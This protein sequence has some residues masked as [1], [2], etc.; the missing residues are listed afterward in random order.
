[1]IPKTAKV[2]VV[3]D[4]VVFRTL[5]QKALSEL[6]YVNLETA[7]NGEEALELLNKAKEAGQPFELVLS[8]W[9][10]PKMDGLDLLKNCRKNEG[11]KALTFVMVTAE[12][13]NHRVNEAF[14]AGAD[15]YI[16]KPIN[17][18]QLA[19]K[20]LIIKQRSPQ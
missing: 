12:A 14:E 15:D 20:L 9:N 5:V 7:T 1:M 4:F 10:M 11:L 6:G 18:N 2:L 3:D 19:D 16:T 13:D 17:K 8:D